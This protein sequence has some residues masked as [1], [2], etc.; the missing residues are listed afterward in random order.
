MCNENHLL[1]D[2]CVELIYYLCIFI[3]LEPITILIVS[4]SENIFINRTVYT[5]LKVHDV[6]RYAFISRVLSSVI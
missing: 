6:V 5:D 3:Y 4:Y 2:F 1:H